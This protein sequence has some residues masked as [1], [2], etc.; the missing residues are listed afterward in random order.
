MTFSWSCAHFPTLVATMMMQARWAVVKRRIDRSLAKAVS[1]D[2]GLDPRA[3]VVGIEGNMVRMLLNST[4][5]LD[6]W[7]SEWEYVTSIGVAAVFRESQVFA[8]K[9]QITSYTVIMRFEHE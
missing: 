3:L 7:V 9:H 1:A 4:R 2:L 6:E 8:H 5:G